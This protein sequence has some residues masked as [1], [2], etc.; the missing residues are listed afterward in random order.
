MQA[1]TLLSS[2]IEF[3]NAEEVPLLIITHRKW[4]DHMWHSRLRVSRMEPN[5]GRDMRVCVREE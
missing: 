2:V 4:F 1:V 3:S 5:E